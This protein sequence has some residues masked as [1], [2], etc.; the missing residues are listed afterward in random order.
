MFATIEIH[1]TPKGEYSAVGKNRPVC[2]ADEEDTL[3]LP[4]YIPFDCVWRTC[5][6][7]LSMEGTLPLSEYDRCTALT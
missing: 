2:V 7:Y 1:R 6:I 3:L 4:E 5:F